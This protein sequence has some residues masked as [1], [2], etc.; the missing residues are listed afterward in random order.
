MM[1]EH[2]ADSTGTWVMAS[3]CM[4]L[5]HGAAM[6]NKLLIIK[7]IFIPFYKDFFLV[8]NI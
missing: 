3:A 7:R 1:A 6:A 2:E 4:L 5:F 8:I